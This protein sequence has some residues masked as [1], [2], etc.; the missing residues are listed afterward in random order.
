MRV[1]ESHV[2]TRVLT[3]VP[4]GHVKTHVLTHEGFAVF[5]PTPEARMKVTQL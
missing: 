4:F 5:P 3:H 1:K 2:K